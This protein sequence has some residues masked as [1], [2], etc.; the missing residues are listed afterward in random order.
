MN[1]INITLPDEDMTKIKVI[2][3]HE[4]YNFLVDDF[5]S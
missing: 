4:L 1:N 5:F 3:I 2:D